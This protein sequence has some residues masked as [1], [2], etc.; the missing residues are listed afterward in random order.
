MRR[1]D[2]GVAYHGWP[3]LEHMLEEAPKSVYEELAGATKPP[4]APPPVDFASTW[5]HA[6][7]PTT[8]DAVL[9]ALEDTLGLVRSL[10]ENPGEGPNAVPMSR[11]HMI[12]LIQAA[13]ARLP[14]PGAPTDGRH[15]NSVWVDLGKRKAGRAYSVL[16]GLSKAYCVANMTVT[17]S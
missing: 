1:W 14:L 13:V 9:K 7:D 12:E 6:Q 5:D 10:A 15:P 11:F 8:A 17:T 4:R 16:W 3:G 2:G